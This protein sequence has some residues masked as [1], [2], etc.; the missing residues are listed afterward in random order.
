VIY[1]GIQAAGTDAYSLELHGVTRTFGTEGGVRVDALS[2][3]SLRVNAGEFVA[4]RGPSGCGKSTLLH[5]LGCLD[6]PSSG[7]YRVAGLDTDALDANDLAWLRRSFFGFV[8]QQYNLLPTATAL[9][10][11][12][13][14]AI[15]AGIP[16]TTRQARAERLLAALGLEERLG[17]KPSQLSGGEQQR[18]AIARALMNGGK[19]ILADEPTGALDSATSME[20]IELLSGLAKQGHTVII[21]THDADVAGRADRQLDMLDG[22][23]V[24]DTDPSLR[25][26]PQSSVS[27]QQL[28]VRRHPA[29]R[30]GI[31]QAAWMALRSLSVTPLRTALTLLGVIIG[32]AAVVA[33]LA[34]GEGAKQRLVGEIDSLGANRLSVWA[35]LRAYP[36]AKL[37]IDDAQAVADRVSN[38]ETVM[39]ILTGHGMLR[40]GNRDHRTTISATTADFPKVR[41]W[42]V[43]RGVF[44][45]ANDDLRYRAVLVLGETL[46]QELF[47]AD[48]D[49]IGQYVL[50]GKVPFLV[51]GTM[52]SKGAS[53]FGGVDQ[54]DVALVPLRTGATRL[55]GRSYL[56]AMIVSVKDSDQIDQAAAD[57]KALL[58]ERHGF[59]DVRIRNSAEMQQSMSK[60]ISATTLILSAIG[61]ISLLVGGIGVMNIMLVSVTER[62]REIGIRVAMGARRGDILIQFLAEAVVITCVGGLVGL[63]VGAGIASLASAVA[64]EIQVAFTAL[65]MAAAF[66][67][68]AAIGIL[69]GYLPARNAAHLDPVTALASD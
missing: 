56:Q 12:E 26:N 18:V 61:A 39:P 13:L 41:D 59:A 52:T 23:I 29:S 28:E 4:I 8:F 22:R 17:H 34:I 57:I 53:G 47:E 51:I 24:H 19:V 43:S 25:D 15:Y 68:A 64:P 36:G 50:I 48:E 7:Q 38:I 60:A 63:G 6:R 20:I 67:C 5:I 1:P 66:G 45:D 40:V 10:N 27:M 46:R 16:S 21:A 49:P 3:V 9:E 42:P 58:T 54:D 62:T 65:P 31:T 37:T 33:L 32:V 35:D 44:F 55:F 2:N 11:T 30:A 69:F 14:P